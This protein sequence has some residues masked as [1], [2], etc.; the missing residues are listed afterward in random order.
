V[1]AVLVDTSVWR[2]YFAGNAGVRE[3][4]SLLDEAGAVLTHPFVIGEM[5]MGGLS[6]REEDLFTRL[7][8]AA[9][10]PHEEVLVFVRHRRLVRRGIGWIDAHLVA[11][12]LAS[13]ALL[14][15][16]DRELA[17]AA[18]ELGVAFTR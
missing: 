8:A 6:T 9:L 7:P 14:W 10:V 15:S 2:K 5:V 17:D 3:L 11:S 18:A 4:G 12:A 16:L 13:S 1:R